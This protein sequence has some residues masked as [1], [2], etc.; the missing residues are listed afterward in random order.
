LLPK[1]GQARR[2]ECSLVVPNKRRATQHGAILG[3]TPILIRTGD[4]ATPSQ[5]ELARSWV[6]ARLCGMATPRSLRLVSHQTD[7]R[8]ADPICV[9][10]P[11]F[12]RLESKR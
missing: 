5:S 2:E 1:W 9:N 10:R 7:R 8:R 12:K 11:F 3:A 6:T 4:G